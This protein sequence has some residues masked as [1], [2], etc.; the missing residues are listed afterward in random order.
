MRP[1]LIL[2]V[3]L[4]TVSVAI[5]AVC[6]SSDVT[7][8]R[9]RLWEAERRRDS[10]ERQLRETESALAARATPRNLLEMEDML[11]VDADLARP[12]ILRPP[13]PPAEP[14]RRRSMAALKFRRC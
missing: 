8:L 3:L 5:V 9:Y 14:A 6:Q 12:H 7:R 10:L 4:A 11:R 1:A 13:P 2:A